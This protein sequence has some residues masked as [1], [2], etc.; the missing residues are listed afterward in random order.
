MAA[1][2]WRMGLGEFYRSF[3]KGA[4]VRALMALIPEIRAQDLV[5]AKAGVRAQALEPG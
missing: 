5:P 3:S 4:F 2:H 1:Q